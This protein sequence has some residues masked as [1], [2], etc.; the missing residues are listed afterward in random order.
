MH[1]TS[2]LLKEFNELKNIVD[3]K[4]QCHLD[5][6]VKYI[7]EV[8][9]A[10]CPPHVPPLNLNDLNS[11]RSCGEEDSAVIGNVDTTATTIAGFVDSFVSLDV[12]DINNM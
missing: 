9:S 11:Y 7:E 6:I 4:S 5:E 8:T 12:A 2:E 1:S 3:E 10:E